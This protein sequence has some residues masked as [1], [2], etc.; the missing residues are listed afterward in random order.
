MIFDEFICQRKL[1]KELLLASLR[2]FEQCEFKIPK[3]FP[4]R[5]QKTL[6]WSTW[7]FDCPADNFPQSKLGQSPEMRMVLADLKINCPI[8]LFQLKIDFRMTYTLGR[9]GRKLHFIIYHF[10]IAVPKI[11]LLPL[12]KKF[13]EPVFSDSFNIN[14]VFKPYNVASKVLVSFLCMGVTNQ[15]R[16][17]KWNALIASQSFH[18]FSAEET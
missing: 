9:H 16:F 6:S 4:W 15:S 3:T 14:F 5:K 10:S 2:Y 12:K 18:I 11:Y 7:I 8:K 1:T 17:F 13:I